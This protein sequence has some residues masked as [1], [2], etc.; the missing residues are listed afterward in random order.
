[1]SG[2][3]T[4]WRRRR[5]ARILASMAR[6]YPVSAWAAGFDSPEELAEAIKRGEGPA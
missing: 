5:R 6:H 2:W 4:R 1:M 3:F